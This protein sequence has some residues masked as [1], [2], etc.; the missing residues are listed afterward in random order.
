MGETG[1]RA[2]RCLLATLRG[3]MRPVTAIAKP[4]VMVPSIFS[5]TDLEPLAG[6]VR[7]SLALPREK[8]GLVDVSL[9]A[10]FSY[11][12]APSCGFSVVAVADGDPALAARAAHTAIDED[13]F[14]EF[15]MRAADFPIIVL[16]SKT[17]FR[18]VYEPLA[19]EILIVDTPDW[20]PADLTG[21][22]YRH[23]P[24]E[25]VFPFADPP[26]LL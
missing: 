16:R 7:R 15:G 19:A 14:T 2:A 5:A 8:P 25:R 1:E 20:G 21:L 23:V 26:Q 13:C 4:G 12:D 17:H 18:A 6:L 22:P 24:R 10:G 11:A 9:F 3:E